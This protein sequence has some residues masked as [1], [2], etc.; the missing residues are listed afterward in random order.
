MCSK[1]KALNIISFAH[2]QTVHAGE[3]KTWLKISE[4]YDN[5]TRDVVSEY[6]RLCDHCNE[7]CRK[8][9]T[10]KGVVVKPITVKDLNERAQIDLVNFCTCADGEYKYI[11]HYVEFST[12]YHILRP[13]KSKKASEVAQELLYIFLDFGAPLVLQS[14]NG[15]EFTAEIISELATLWPELKLVNGQPRHPQSQ[16][17]VERS[18]GDIKN[19]LTAWMKDNNSTKWSLGIRL[20]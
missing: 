18:N 2:Q 12:K 10:A 6:I 13:L 15:W 9:E 5:I 7:K 1:T 19:K 16:G 14:D 20:I 8:T 3:K 4:Q 11:L 17:S